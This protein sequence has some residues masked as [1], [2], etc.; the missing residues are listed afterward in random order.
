MNRII[1]IGD[2]HGRVGWKNIVKTIQ[3]VHHIVFLGDYVDSYDYSPMECAANLLEIIDF[4]KK[5]PTKVTLLLGNHDYAYIDE[6]PG[7][8]GYQ[9]HYAAEYRRIFEENKDLFQLAWGYTHG[10]KYY[11]ATHAGL[12]YSWYKEYMLNNEFLK[13]IHDQMDEKTLS[14]LKLHD[15]LNFLKDK[16]D[17]VWTVGYRRGGAQRPGPIWADFQE[18]IENPYPGINQIIGHTPHGIIIYHTEDGVIHCVD[19]GGNDVL[20]ITMNI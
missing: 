12:N 7:T 2:I 19:G 5:F 4:K 3:T 15:N 11:L 10:N 8:S 9:V 16:R 6:H 13:S 14:N 20:F 17:I 1:F 18:L